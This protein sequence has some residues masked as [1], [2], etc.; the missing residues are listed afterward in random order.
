[1][2]KE[3]VYAWMDKQILVD[4]ILGKPLNP[5]D[6]YNVCIAGYTGEIHVY[7]IDKLCNMLGI[8]WKVKHHSDEYDCHYITYKGYRFFGLVNKEKN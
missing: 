3:K 6:P 7:G 2:K 1:M 8:Q 4:K 5:K